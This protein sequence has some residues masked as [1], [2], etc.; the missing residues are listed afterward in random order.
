MDE[1][2][3]KLVSLQN[4]SVRLFGAS[5]KTQLLQPMELFTENPFWEDWEAA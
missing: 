3:G 1:M 2:V 5:R 4:G